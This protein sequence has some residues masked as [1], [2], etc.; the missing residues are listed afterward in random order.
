MLEHRRQPIAPPD[1]F[2]RRLAKSASSALAVVAAALF[3][4]VLGYHVTENLPWIDALLN[5]AMILGGMGPVAELHTM[6]GK[7]FAAGYALFSG[8]V[9]MIVAGILFTPILHRFLHRFHL[10]T[11]ERK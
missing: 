10:E 9:F 2:L 1:V 7:L 8:L 6:A 3:L 11:G 4:G 5:A